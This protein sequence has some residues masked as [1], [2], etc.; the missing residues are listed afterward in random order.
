MKTGPIK[1]CQLNFTFYYAFP[2]SLSE[3]VFKRHSAIGE[4]DSERSNA[5]PGKNIIDVS[6]LTRWRFFAFRVKGRRHSAPSSALFHTTDTTASVCFKKPSH[7]TNN[8]DQ[9]Q[10]QSH[11]FRSSQLFCSLLHSIDLLL[12]SLLTMI[13]SRFSS[14]TRLAARVAQRSFSS[15]ECEPATKLR[16]VFE[17]YRKEQ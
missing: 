14:T 9:D 12:L 16:N 2:D 8:N 1:I 11:C 10:R 17:E 7:Q 13:A 6:S 3:I 15:F 5:N 4:K